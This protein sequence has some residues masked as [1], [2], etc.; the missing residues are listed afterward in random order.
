[1][2]AFCACM[3]SIAPR[4]LALDFDNVGLLVEPDHPEIKTVLLALDCTSVTA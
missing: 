1:M 3:E 2:K 4:A